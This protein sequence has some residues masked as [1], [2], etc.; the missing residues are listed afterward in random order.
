MPIKWLT[1]GFEFVCRVLI[2]VHAWLVSVPVNKV[3]PK[4]R[5]A[6]FR[7]NCR[8]VRHLVG[9]QSTLLYSKRNNIIQTT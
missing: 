5:S 9:I 6:A 1:R 7:R 8:H 3:G 4:P 2:V